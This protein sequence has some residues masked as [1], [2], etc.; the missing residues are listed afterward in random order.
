MP[1]DVVYEPTTSKNCECTLLLIAQT[2]ILNLKVAHNALTDDLL[3]LCSH[4]VRGYCLKTK[5]WGK[6][7]VI[8]QRRL[9]LHRMID[10]TNVATFSVDGIEDLKW[11]EGAFESLVLPDDYKR[12]ITAFVESQMNNKSSFDDIIEGKGNAKETIV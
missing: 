3:Y 2:L 1:P 7:I 4:K 8:S 10:T 12:L 9:D 11:N 5:D 6:F